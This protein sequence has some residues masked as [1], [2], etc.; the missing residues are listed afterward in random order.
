MK[1]K[2]TVRE[3]WVQPYLVEGASSPEEAKEMVAADARGVV[4]LENEGDL[5]HVML[6]HT[7]TVE[8]VAG[9]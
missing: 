8:E 1:Y 5:S 7:W 6:S 2:V 3:V 9:D 4:I